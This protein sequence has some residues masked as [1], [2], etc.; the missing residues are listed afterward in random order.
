MSSI[1]RENKSWRVSVKILDLIWKAIT[2]YQYALWALSVKNLPLIL[3]PLQCFKKF[4][5]HYLPIAFPFYCFFWTSVDT[6][7]KVVRKLFIFFLN[8]L[9]SKKLPADCQWKPRARHWFKA[10]DTNFLV[11][12]WISAWTFEKL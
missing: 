6:S 10:D 3:Y 9:P 8:W 5:N 12:Y 1:S 2:S 4:E 7:N 11:H